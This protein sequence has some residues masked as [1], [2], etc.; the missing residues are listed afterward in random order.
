MKYLPLFALLALLFFCL[1]C[2]AETF[3]DFS[4]GQASGILA[5]DT[6]DGKFTLS[7]AGG[8]N[9]ARITGTPQSRMIYLDV[10]DPFPAGEKAFVIVEYY[11]MTGDI[12]LQYDGSGNPYFESPDRYGQNDTGEWKT[13][14]FLLQ[15]PV[16]QNRENAGHD[17][18][19][20]CEKDLAVRRV[21]VTSEKPLF[22][23]LPRDPVAEL[24]AREPNVLRDGMTAIQQWQIHEPLAPE[25][26]TDAAFLRAKKLGITSM[27]SYVGLRQ[28]EP[29]EGELDFSYYDGLTGQLEKHG[30]KWLPFLI[31]APEISVPDWWNSRYG[32]FAKCLEHGEEA[33]VQSIWNPNLREG[34][35]RFL[36]IFREHYKPELIEA[37]N[38]GISGCWGESIQVAGGGFGIMDRHQHMGYW[39]GDIYAAE[40]FRSYMQQKYG[41][42]D[43]LN[44]AWKTGFG[45]FDALQPFIPNETTSKRAAKDLNDWYYSSMTDLAEFWVK[46]ARELYPDTPIY[47]CTGGDG[48]VKLGADFSD[49]A[50]RIAPY[51]AGIRI[52]NENDDVMSNF[53]VT[54][55][56]SSACRLYG[57]YYTT[58]PGGDNTPD[59]IPGRVFDATAGGAIGAYFKY[60]MDKPDLPN[61]R[62]I[63]FAENSAF[64]RRNTP[65]L[66]VAA[67]MPNTSIGLKPEVIDRFI[68]LSTTLRR[69]QDFEWVDENM[70][71]DG[72]LSRFRAVVLLAGQVYEQSTLDRLEEWVKA[73]GVLLSSNETLPLTTPEDGECSW[74]QPARGAF[75]GALSMEGEAGEGYAIDVGNRHE[76]GLTGIWHAGEGN[77]LDPS[78]SGRWTAGDSSA[79][80][81]LPSGD[82]PVLKILARNDPDHG[83]DCQVLADGEP[84]GVLGKSKVPVW[85]RFELPA[86]K[87]SGRIRVTFRSNTFTGGANDPRQLG[88]FVQEIMLSSRAAEKDDIEDMEDTSLV[89][90]AVDDSR[91]ASSFTPLGKG[92]TG[93]FPETSEEYLALV[94]AALY[95]EQAPWSAALA[96]S[97]L[98]NGRCLAGYK[99]DGD[100]DEVI[101]SVI[102]TPEGQSVY[103]YNNSSEYLQKTLPNG[104]TIAVP[105]YSFAELTPDEA[106]AP[107]EL[108]ASPIKPADSG[109]VSPGYMLSYTRGSLKDYA[110]V[111]EPAEEGSDWV[112]V[113]HGH[114][115]VAD[116]LYTRQDLAE[117]WLPELADKYGIVT[118]DTM[119]NGWMNPTVCSNIHEMLSWLRAKYRVDKFTII[120]GSMGGSGALAYAAC[121]PDD[122]KGVLALCPCTDL[123]SYTEFLSRAEPGDPVAA[124]KKDILDTI[125]QKFD[126]S[127]MKMKAVSPQRYS[128]RLPLPLFIAHST[129]D[130]LIPVEN[131]R[132]L[133]ELMEGLSDFEYMEMEGGGHDTTILPGFARGLEF[134]REQGA[135]Q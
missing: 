80:M 94:S 99:T 85:S 120:G 52:T 82:G 25:D 89:R 45:G 28:L 7:P 16:W 104:R 131:S 102:H 116:Q 49:Q 121:Y 118:F 106:F 20:L 32:V 86:G 23:S 31:M 108:E 55:M 48:N 88:V 13:C 129:G 51:H 71:E 83:V 56:V 135:L 126:Q 39:C 14:V 22:Y 36:T 19:I 125:L 112:I 40:S 87:Y 111:R 12:S 127:E 35:R 78:D 72:L 114:G 9:T 103:Y 77:V 63:R 90:Y 79:V 100:F 134:L 96:D 24:E 69:A 75:S 117:N 61:I 123:K 60:L 133:A 95:W 57:A 68:A 42:I 65:D 124:I 38:F 101:A 74:I 128:E 33:P 97:S 81:P 92:W 44:K 15:Y 67:L 119:G 76:S 5:H 18:R 4:A 122:I 1:P 11:D 50:R 47:L 58:E 110:L 41:S 70:T 10:T 46:T 84:I 113:L 30:M 64:F 93:V 66:K 43:A 21:E 29:R 109:A 17:F 53:S 34:V 26:L 2:S 37:L 8:V 98:P 132:I 107:A 62:G 6:N 105:E 59:G 54:R 130:E 27:Q 91:L 115:S 3:I 73:G